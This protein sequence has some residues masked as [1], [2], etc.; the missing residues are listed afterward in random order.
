MNSQKIISASSK[1]CYGM[2]STDFNVTKQIEY[3]LYVYA[4]RDGTIDTGDSVLLLIKM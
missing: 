1:I 3:I 4:K 2:P